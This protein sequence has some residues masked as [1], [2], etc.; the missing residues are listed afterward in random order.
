MSR[1]GAHVQVVERGKLTKARKEL[2][3]MH[4]CATYGT[5]MKWWIEMK[6][7]RS[8]EYFFFLVARESSGNC[9]YCS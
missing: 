2:D 3:E 5:A 8:V 4:I 7:M 9:V 6:T 1:M